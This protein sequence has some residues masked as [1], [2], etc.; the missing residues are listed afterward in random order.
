MESLSRI[1]KFLLGHIW[2]GYAGKIYFS[3]GSSSAESYLGEM[4]AEEFTSR[5][6]RFFMKLAEEFKKAIS[7]LRDNWIIE[8]SGFEASLTSYGQQLIKELSKEEYKK[9]MEEIKKGNI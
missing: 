8:I 1:E 7:K 5:D 6:Q 3:R 9:I 2:Y 4:F